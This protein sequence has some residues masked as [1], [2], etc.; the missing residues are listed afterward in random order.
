[1]VVVVVCDQ[2]EIARFAF[3]GTLAIAGTVIKGGVLNVVL[4]HVMAVVVVKLRLFENAWI[5][6]IEIDCLFNKEADKDTLWMVVEVIELEKL[7]NLK[8]NQL[9][10][11]ELQ[12]MSNFGTVKSKFL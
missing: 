6:A 9:N 4:D 10:L 12:N 8:I 3:D 1:M 11:I 7:V 2:I 5:R